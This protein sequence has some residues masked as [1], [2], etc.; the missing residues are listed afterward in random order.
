MSCRNVKEEEERFVSATMESRKAM[1][2]TPSFVT[3]AD[4]VAG[5]GNWTVDVR[6]NASTIVQPDVLD[7]RS[8][9]TKR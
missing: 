5:Q 4:H 2:T 6:L 9:G 8:N 7:S 3:A 1:S